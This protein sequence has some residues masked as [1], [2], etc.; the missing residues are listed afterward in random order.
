MTFTPGR[1]LQLPISIS[2]MAL[3]SPKL[4]GEFLVFSCD[5]ILW[6]KGISSHFWNGF[7]TSS[8]VEAFTQMQLCIIYH[9]D[10]CFN[11]SWTISH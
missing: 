3:L 7:S 6:L 1:M 5:P 10:E 9:P 2:E 11:S 4:E 8:G